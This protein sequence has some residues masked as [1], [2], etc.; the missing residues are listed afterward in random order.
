M[1]EEND[2]TEVK[3]ETLSDGNILHQASAENLP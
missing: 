1:I 2:L 3:R